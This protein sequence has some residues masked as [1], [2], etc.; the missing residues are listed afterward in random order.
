M[1][2]ETV[3]NPV[4]PAKAADF[5]SVI[6]NLVARVRRLLADIDSKRRLEFEHRRAIAHLK[7]LT[8]AQLRDIGIASADIER[9][10]RGG[11]EQF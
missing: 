9:V 10:V 2:S 1:I 11:R 3:Q 7:S 5:G 8:D 4:Q 6:G